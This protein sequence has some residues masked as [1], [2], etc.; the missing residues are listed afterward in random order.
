MTNWSQFHPKYPIFFLL[1]LL[2]PF[3]FSC[4]RESPPGAKRFEALI[5]PK[6]MNR[7]LNKVIQQNPNR[8]KPG[9][10]EEAHVANWL[11]DTFSDYGLDPAGNRQTYYV[12][13]PLPDNNN[14][15]FGR[16]VV[17]QVTWM[18]TIHG[19]ILVTTIYNRLNTEES[20]SDSDAV[21]S[22]AG[23]LAVLLEL[24]NATAGRPGDTP[25]NFSARSGRPIPEAKN[26]STVVELR[27]GR[28][29]DDTLR[30]V[31]DSIPGRWQPFLDNLSDSVMGV[32]FHYLGISSSKTPDVKMSIYLPTKVLCTATNKNQ[33]QEALE[34]L[35]HS[36]QII[37]KLLYRLAMLQ[38]AISAPEDSTS[39]APRPSN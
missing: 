9:T 6:G 3:L 7:S 34:N 11:A 35:A 19:G 10:P 8:A 29:T 39:F 22:S 31:A 38:P 23:R 17:G 37:R 14:H 27:N 36:A 18:R 15:S 26:I 1:L 12:E 2:L 30:I 16:N 20:Q 32:S 25:I 13:Y 4:H 28:R 33:H 21:K 24:V 5:T